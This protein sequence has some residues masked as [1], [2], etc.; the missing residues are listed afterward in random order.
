MLHRLT[1]V[2]YRASGKS[3]IGRIVADRLHWPFHDADVRIEQHLGTSI[4]K[5]FAQQGE[6][7]FRKAESAIL[8]DIL[9]GS[10]PLILS[11][12]GGA[13]LAVENRDL[14]RA[15][16]GTVVYLEASAAVLQARLR[17]DA[18]DRP[19][20]SGADICEEVPAILAKRAPLYHNVAHRVVD[21]GLA[22]GEIVTAVLRIVENLPEIR[23]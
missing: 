21:A 13:V 1:L 15:R 14:L 2:G 3:T 9:A 18:G 4:A 11:T 17:A 7:A 22:P 20:L 23:Q 10:E 5:C 6:A 8:V 12:G 16:G 19:S